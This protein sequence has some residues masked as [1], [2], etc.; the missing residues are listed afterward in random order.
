M[1][2]FQERKKEKKTDIN[3]FL[4]PKGNLNF[5][6]GFM[7]GWNDGC[8]KFNEIIEVKIRFPIDVRKRVL[9]FLVNI[10]MKMRREIFN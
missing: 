2:N 7:G 5:K 4:L 8:K 3:L 6:K 1:E 9:F 10:Q